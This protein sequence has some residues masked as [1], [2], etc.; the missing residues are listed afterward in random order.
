MGSVVWVTRS[1]NIVAKT[2]NLPFA[3]GKVPTPQANLAI[4]IIP[5]DILVSLKCLQGILLEC[6]SVD[7]TVLAAIDR[8]RFG[9]HHAVTDFCD[10]NTRLAGGQ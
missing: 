8:K 10:F 4:L 5:G 6:L 1:K 7:G 3:V 2:N 9:V